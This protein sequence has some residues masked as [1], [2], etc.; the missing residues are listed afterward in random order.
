MVG[1]NAFASQRDRRIRS[2]PPDRLESAGEY[3][4]LCAG[5]GFTRRPHRP[6]VDGAKDGELSQPHLD[7][8]SDPIR[9]VRMVNQILRHSSP[10]DL[11]HHPHEADG[12]SKTTWQTTSLAHHRLLHPGKLDGGGTI[13]KLRRAPDCQS[14][15]CSF[16]T[17]TD[18]GMVL[19]ACDGVPVLRTPL[20]EFPRRVS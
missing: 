3:D 10:N 16:A 17:Y 13:R 11:F 6:R 1:F 19:L 8:L 14:G 12:V 9:L 5:D 4:A 18:D 7:L 2:S 20:K 15:S